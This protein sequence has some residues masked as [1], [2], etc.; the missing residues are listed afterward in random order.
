MMGLGMFL[1]IST[2]HIY[3][4][5]FELLTLKDSFQ[6]WKNF[7]YEKNNFSVFSSSGTLLFPIAY[8]R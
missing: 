2:L 1:L 3:L 7:D 5:D 4:S 6:I 8:R